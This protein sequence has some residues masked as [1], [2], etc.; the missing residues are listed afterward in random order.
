LDDLIDARA[1]GKMDLVVKADRQ[2]PVV[3]KAAIWRTVLIHISPCVINNLSVSR[4]CVFDKPPLRNP[5]CKLIV[6][7]CTDSPRIK[8][9]HPVREKIEG[10]AANRYCNGLNIGLQKMR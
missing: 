6:A 7:N 1:A 8:Y 3:G 5:D 2:L 4:C 10:L 9:Q